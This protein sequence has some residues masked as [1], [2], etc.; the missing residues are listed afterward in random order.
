MARKQ[1]IYVVVR[2]DGEVRAAKRP[3]LGPDEVAI[4]LNLSFP[5]GWGHITQTFDLEMPD[6]PVVT[7]PPRVDADG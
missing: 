7:E 3:R 4:A 5:E 6:P 2:S 1:T